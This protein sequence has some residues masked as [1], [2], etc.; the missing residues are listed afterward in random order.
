MYTSSIVLVGERWWTSLSETYDYIFSM[1]ERAGERVIQGKS[2]VVG[3]TPTCRGR[4]VAM[5]MEVI[6]IVAEQTVCVAEL[7]HTIRL[8]TCCAASNPT[9]LLKIRDVIVRST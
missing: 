4:Y 1:D 7:H 5:L 2:F 9:S 8:D 6:T 3:R